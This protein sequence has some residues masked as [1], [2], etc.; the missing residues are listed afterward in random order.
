MLRKLA[1]AAA[2][3]P[4]AACNAEMDRE[5]DIR[6]PAASVVGEPVSCLNLN[7]IQHQ[8]VHDDYT[9]DFELSNG[10][11][12]RNTL[13]GRCPQLGFERAI[14]FDTTM[15]RLCEGEI[16][17]VLRQGGDGLERGAAC[18]LGEFVPIE[19]AGEQ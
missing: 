1:L 14:T 9:I 11:L 10:R 18:G 15:N 8:R 4:L 2:I 5:P 16:I 19:L 3:L 6:A 13:D 17:Y 7:Q 12:Y